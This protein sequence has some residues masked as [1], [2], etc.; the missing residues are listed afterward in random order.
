MAGH[1]EG[2]VDEGDGAVPRQG[3]VVEGAVWEGSG[4]GSVGV[5]D[6]LGVGDRGRRPAGLSDVERDGVGSQPAEIAYG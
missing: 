6:V 5:D 4:S 2:L 3:S 1:Q